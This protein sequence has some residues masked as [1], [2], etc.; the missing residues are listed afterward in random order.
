[1]QNYI[2]STL[3]LNLYKANAL[4]SG[5]T[6]NLGD[7]IAYNKDNPDNATIPYAI[8][9]TK[10]PDILPYYK[11]EKDEDATIVDIEFVNPTLD[12]KFNMG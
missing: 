8:I 2:S 7:L 3:N 10:T 5:T 12:Y 4:S 6:I 9:T 1:V 11:V